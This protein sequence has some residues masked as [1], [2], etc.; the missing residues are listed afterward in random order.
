MELVMVVVV[1]HIR[2]H[3]LLAVIGRKQLLRRVNYC[4]VVAG[5]FAT[6]QP[7]PVIT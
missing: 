5:E 1:A 4:K 2:E 6:V 7:T 3:E